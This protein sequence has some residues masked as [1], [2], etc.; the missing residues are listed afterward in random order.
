MLSQQ[1]A[2]GRRTVAQNYNSTFLSPLLSQFIWSTRSKPVSLDRTSNSLESGWDW[3]TNRGSPLSLYSPLAFS[4]SP[5][6]LKTGWVQACPLLSLRSRKVIIFGRGPH[7][8]GPLSV[9]VLGFKYS[10]RTHE[11]SCCIKALVCRAELL[12][13]MLDWFDLW[14][15][16]ERGAR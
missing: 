5:F 1:T 10:K 7:E 3:I 15:R 9:E 11:K 14:Q 13:R 12:N 8:L 2:W 4:L 16:K 6:T